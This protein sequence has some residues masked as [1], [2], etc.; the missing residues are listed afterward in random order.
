MILPR[1]FTATDIVLLSLAV[2]LAATVRVLYLTTFAAGGESAGPLRVQDP[3]RPVPAS[4]LPADEA[5]PRETINELDELAASLVRDGTFSGHA[6]FATQAE[7]TAHVAPLYPALLALLEARL[8]WPQRDRWAR[9]LNVLFGSLT[10]GLCYL[11]ARRAF[12]SRSAGILTS[13][14]AA[15]HPGWIVQTADVSDGVLTGLLL[16]LGLVQFLYANERGGLIKSVLFGLTLG[17]LMLARGS[18]WPFVLVAVV[19]YALRCSREFT[20]GWLYGLLML[21]GVLV[22]F[23]PWT[24]RN[25]RAVHTFQPIVD[26]GAY[27]FWVGNNPQATGGPL[28]EADLLAVYAQQVGKEADEAKRELGELPQVRRYTKL[29]ELAWRDILAR[30]SEALQRRA[31]ATL[32]FFTG[33]DWLAHRRLWQGSIE[34]AEA[35]STLYA[36]GRAIHAGYFVAFSWLMLGLALLGW[37]WSFAYREESAPLGLALLAVPLPVVLTH[38]TA[39]PMHRLPLDGVLLALAAFAVLWLFPPTGS[40][41]RARAAGEPTE[42]DEE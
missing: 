21:L 3:P 36:A 15:L 42:S 37:R 7:R 18:M 32:S 41:L 27:H 29:E 5:N 8:G 19:W 33:H 2:V 39:L 12:A 35:E 4:A 13:Y 14:A 31:V 40:L 10:V 11:L 25:T 9:W 22:T 38:A 16:T 20:Q 6:P 34:P 17:L 30:P 23:L 26:S 28:D 1:R 24:V